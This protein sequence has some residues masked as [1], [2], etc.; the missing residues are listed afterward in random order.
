M[1]T[2]IL[3]KTEFY[4]YYNGKLIY[5]KWLNTNTSKIFQDYK[6]WKTKTV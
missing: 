3:T 1:F 4:L 2:K 5:K 6:I